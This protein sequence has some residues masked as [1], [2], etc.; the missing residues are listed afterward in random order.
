MGAAICGTAPADFEGIAIRCCVL[1][2]GLE[3]GGE[4]PG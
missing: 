2:L 4:L 3:K 1:D